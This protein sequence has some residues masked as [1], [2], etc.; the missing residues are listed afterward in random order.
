MSD[1][2]GR[3]FWDFSLDVYA[4]PGVQE[5]C[6]ALQERLSL[7]V[8]VLLFAAYAGARLGIALSARDLAELITATEDWQVSVVRR[9]RATR[10]SM[11]KWSEDNSDPLQ[12]PA[13]SLRLAIKQ[14]ELDAERI[15]HDRLALWASGRAANLADSLA[16]SLAGS[17]R[18]AVE[19]NL[20]L[21]I[22]HHAKASGGSAD[23]PVRL[24]AA[25]LA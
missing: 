12:A 21:V 14:A 18:Q 4:Q 8:N 15:E 11:K 23:M 1:L 13:A 25:A 5:E 19:Q 6:L 22:G 2:S 7:D 24:V 20:R 10:V 3:A 9:L 17:R 16:D